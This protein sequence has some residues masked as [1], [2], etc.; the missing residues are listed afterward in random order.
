MR[1][2]SSVL[3]WIIALSTSLS[4]QKSDELTLIKEKAEKG[5]AS[6]Q[7]ALGNL[8][9]SGKNVPKDDTQAASWFRK[10]AVQ[11]NAEAQCIYGMCLSFALGVQRNRQEAISWYRKAADQGNTQGQFML[12]VCYLEGHGVSRNPEQAFALFMKTRDQAYAS[13]L[14]GLFRCYDKGLGVKKDEIEA[15]AY[16]TQPTIG[17]SLI[18][19]GLSED[20]F[21]KSISDYEKNL[22]A[23]QIAAG[24]RRSIEIQKEIAAKKAGR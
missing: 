21:R 13:G 8:L 19:E 14:M 22:S 9:R 1:S 7:L 17:L 5:D 6:A 24:K 11:G 10:A 23:D 16:L 4:A 2:L 12:G 18:A 15:Y 3:I 20:D